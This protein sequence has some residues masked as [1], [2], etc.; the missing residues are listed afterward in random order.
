MT[1]IVDFPPP[2]SPSKGG[3]TPYSPFG[4]GEGEEYVSMEID[5]QIIH[6]PRY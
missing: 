3:H 4:G 1:K 5:Y 6:V 2:K